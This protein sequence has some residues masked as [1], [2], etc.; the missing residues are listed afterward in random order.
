MTKKEYWDAHVK[1]NPSLADE[2][3]RVEVKVSTLRALLEEA[4]DKGAEHDRKV[5]ESVKK[6]FDGFDLGGFKL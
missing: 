6:I 4:Y 1:K 5:R 2:D 3:A